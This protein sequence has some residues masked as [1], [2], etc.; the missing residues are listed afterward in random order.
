MCAFENCS[1]ERKVEETVHFLCA[2]A[3]VIAVDEDSLFD[4]ISTLKAFVTKD[5]MKE[6]DMNNVNVCARWTEVFFSFF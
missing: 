4:E 2:K 5:K 3:Q 1:T 6:W